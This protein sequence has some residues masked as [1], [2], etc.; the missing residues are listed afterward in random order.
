MSAF[1]DTQFRWVQLADIIRA[2]IEDGTYPPGRAIPSEPAMVQEFGVAR[3]TI[4]RAVA[5][6]REEGLLY[7]VPQLG[8]FP[9]DQGPQE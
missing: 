3:N 7:T 1:R 9:V 4:R 6:L 5:S 8:T 2:R